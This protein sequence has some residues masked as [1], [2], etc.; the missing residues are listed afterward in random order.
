MAD[1][2]L[3]LISTTGTYM[4][5]RA[6]VMRMCMHVKIRTYVRMSVCIHT[7]SMYTPS[8]LNVTRSLLLCLYIVPNCFHVGRMDH[9]QRLLHRMY[10]DKMNRSPLHSSLMSVCTLMW[11]RWPI[12]YSRVFTVLSIKYCTICHHRGR[13]NTDLCGN[14]KEYVYAIMIRLYIHIYMYV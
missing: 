4:C 2:F 10:R 8:S 12:W 9:A 5:E 13:K 6:C 14:C 1:Q 3:T 7:C 11:W